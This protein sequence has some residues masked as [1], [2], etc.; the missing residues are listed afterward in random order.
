MKKKKEGVHAT[1]ICLKLP[2]SFQFKR[3]VLVFLL[4]LSLSNQF[5]SVFFR[6][7]KEQSESDETKA[8]FFVLFKLKFFI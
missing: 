6:I 3:V 4:L 7:I 5:H 1:I 8:L 2:M